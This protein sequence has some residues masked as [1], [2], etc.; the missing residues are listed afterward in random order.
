MIFKHQSLRLNDDVI[1]L[2]ARASSLPD[3][4]RKAFAE[5]VALKFMAAL[6]DEEDDEDGDS[7]GRL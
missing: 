7:V 5:Q 6:G 4:E 1:I 2:Q 3:E